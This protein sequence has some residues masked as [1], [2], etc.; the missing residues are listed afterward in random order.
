M[1]R[2]RLRFRGLP[3][4]EKP[5]RRCRVLRCGV[6]DRASGGQCGPGRKDP[7]R[8]GNGSGGAS[9]GETTIRV[10]SGPADVLDEP[11]VTECNTFYDVGPGGLQ[12]SPAPRFSRSMPDVPTPPRTPGEDN[13]AVLR[14]WR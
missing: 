3:H 2:R 11:H 5:R 9:V 6:D 14:G 7:R 13:D 1:D 12:P 8:P 4:P 10:T